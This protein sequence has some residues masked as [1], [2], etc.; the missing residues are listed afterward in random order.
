LSKS[1]S[2]NETPAY[3]TPQF[4][5]SKD[6]QAAYDGWYYTILGA[7]GDPVPWIQGTTQTFIERGIGKPVA[8]YYTTGAEVNAFAGDGVAG[9]DRFQDDLAILMFPLDGLGGDLSYFRLANAQ[10]HQWFYDVINNMRPVELEEKEV[11]EEVDLYVWQDDVMD[12]AMELM[13]ER[14]SNVR[15]TSA[16]FSKCLD[17]LLDELASEA[18][19]NA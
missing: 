11:E 3:T 1:K 19:V 6:L 4:M 16:Q 7:G 18:E 12:R 10:R 17:E 8:W 2:K 5:G 9:Q 15:L 14:Y 13:E